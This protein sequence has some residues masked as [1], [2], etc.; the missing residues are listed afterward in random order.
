MRENAGKKDVYAV[1]GFNIQS[2]KE[3]AYFDIKQVE[4]AQG[5]RQKWFYFTTNQEGLPRFDPHAPLVK[6][7][8]WLH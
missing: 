8:A 2:R 3:V 6:T 4:S 7:R 5:W 1:G